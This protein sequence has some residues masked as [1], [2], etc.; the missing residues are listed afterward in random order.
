MRVKTDRLVG[1]PVGPG[2]LDDLR[3]LFQDE[4][5]GATLGGTRSEAEVEAIVDHDAR[6]WARHGYGVWAWH[7]P[8]SGRFVGRAGLRTLP[9]LGSVETE[10]AYALMPEWWR[11]GLGTEMAVA[12]VDYA[13]ETAGLDALVAFTMPTN[14]G[15]RRVMENA[16]FVFDREF[17]YAN[18]PHVLYRLTKPTLSSTG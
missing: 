14:A 13:F 16:G 9:L 17:T 2:D 15:S 5:V 6:H 18:L 7:E 4:R 1:H 12:S 11:R 3:A 10:V 8:E